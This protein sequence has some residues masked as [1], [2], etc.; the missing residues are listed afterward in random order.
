MWVFVISSLETL[1]YQYGPKGPGFLFEFFATKRFCVSLLHNRFISS[2]CQGISLHDHSSL[3][4]R[5]RD[6]KFFLFSLLS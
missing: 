4:I 6:S 3:I 2:D 5:F 1:Y